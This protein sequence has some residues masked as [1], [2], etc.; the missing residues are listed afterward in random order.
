MGE[1]PKIKV[2]NKFILIVIFL[3]LSVIYVLAAS[4]TTPTT[5]SPINES[6][7]FETDPSLSCSG[8]TDGDGDN[9]FYEFWIK[10]H[11][12]YRNWL[13]GFPDGGADCIVALQA[14]SFEW[15]DN[16]CSTNYYAL[17]ENGTDYNISSDKVN[18]SGG[19]IYCEENISNGYRYV[20]IDSE[21]EQT[22]LEG[23]YGSFDWWIGLNDIV[24]EG[25][26][27]WDNVTF[28]LA[29]NT[30]STTYDWEITNGTVGIWRCRSIDDNDDT[31]S[32]TL[33]RNVYE[34]DFIN[35]TSG[36][37]ALNFTFMDEVTGVFSNG[38]I[39]AFTIEFPPAESYFYSF[40]EPTL[41]ATDYRFCLDSNNVNVSVESPIQFSFG[42]DYP[43][44]ILELDRIINSGSQINQILYLLDTDDGI[45][46]S[47]QVQSAGGA[48]IGDVEIQLARNQIPPSNNVT[49]YTILQ[50][51]TDGA[52]LATFWVNPNAQYRLTLSKAG[53][54]T[55]IKYLYPTQE[56]YTVQL[57]LSASG[58]EYNATTE[59]MTWTINPPIGPL[60]RSITYTF[61]FNITA[62]LG[63]LIGCKFEIY[64]ESSDIVA[65]N[66]GCTAQSTGDNLSD[67][68]QILQGDKLWGV[69]YIQVNATCSDSECDAGPLQGESCSVD[70]DCLVDGIIDADAYWTEF[71]I[72]AGS[73]SI[74]RIIQD[75][76]TLSDFGEGNEQEFSRIF[77]FFLFATLVIAGLSYFT[78][79]DFN[80]PGSAILLIAPLVLIFSF[81]GFF[82]IAMF[83]G[84]DTSF[85]SFLEQFTVAIITVCFAAGYLIN[86]IRRETIS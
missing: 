38:T 10:E 37:I 31:S 20:S 49:W 3:L 18:W 4:P 76:T 28:Y 47:I 67:T 44:R 11:G 73:S 34:M 7:Y 16:F 83:R 70:A 15:V 77:W 85:Q 48:P 58:I 80:S 25:N 72:T 78:G 75:L 9:V 51:N 66:S 6:F 36:N 30:S 54:G 32:Y 29:Q 71:N 53:Y 59:G 61:E 62:S 55:Q 41:N 33:S 86:H 63:N 65:N 24:V 50:Q 5:I 45:Y 81:A 12:R 69:Y 42:D 39:N 21:I 13:A 46:S 57:P 8:S 64:N 79:W 17:C 2:K 60:N 74:K 27:V 14:V 40:S 52:G 35:C 82:E 26:Y 22:Y 84:A 68:Y 56:T 19:K 43:S 23:E 1:K